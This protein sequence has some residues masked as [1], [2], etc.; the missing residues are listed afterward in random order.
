[1]FGQSITES[2]AGLLFAPSTSLFLYSP[3]VVV[4]IAALVLLA[5]SDRIDR[6]APERAGSPLPSIPR[7]RGK[8]AGGSG[9]WLALPGAGHPSALCADG[10]LVS[11]HRPAGANVRRVHPRCQRA[12]SDSG[13]LVDYSKME[14]EHAQQSPPVPIFERMWSWDPADLVLNTRAAIRS[15]PVNIRYLSGIDT[16]PRVTRTAAKEQKDFGQ[17]FAFSLDF[18][19]LYL[20]YLGVVSAPIALCGLLVPLAVAIGCASRLRAIVRA[21]SAG[22]L[23]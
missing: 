3:I 14:Q 12:H 13:V 8:L 15:I 17:Q 23:R 2:V 18:W 10:F 22:T 1:M 19:W 20:F 5:R 16:P 6:P 21:A 11:R 9:L 4:G 7:Q